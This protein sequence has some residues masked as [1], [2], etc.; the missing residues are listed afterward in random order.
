MN[1]GLKIFGHCYL[2]SAFV[3][4]TTIFLKGYHC[5]KKCGW[6]FWLFSEFDS[7][8]TG[9]FRNDT[10]KISGTHFSYK[11]EPKEGKHFY[12]TVTNIKRVLKIWKV[13]NLMLKGSSISDIHNLFSI[14][15]NNR[16]NAYRKWTWK[17]TEVL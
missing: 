12:T 6:L 15:E 8:G 10:L 1:A 11:E 17:N 3:D 13:R 14:F 4:G 9:E 5:Y 2:Y 16:L 7:L